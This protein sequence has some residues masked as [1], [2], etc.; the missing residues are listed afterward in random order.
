MYAHSGVM[1]LY[2]SGRSQQWHAPQI[3][4]TDLLTEETNYYFSAWVFIPEDSSK[5]SAKFTIEC[6]VN[7]ET[8]WNQIAAPVKIT[9]GEWTLIEGKYSY[10]FTDEYPLFYIENLDSTAE[11]YVDDVE[12]SS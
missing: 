5:S 6:L 2:V 9:P 10:K 11:F 3:D 4:V 7:G 1:S 12:I 8:R